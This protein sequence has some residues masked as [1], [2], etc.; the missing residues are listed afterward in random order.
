[1]NPHSY[2]LSFGEITRERLFTVEAITLFFQ[3]ILNEQV[4]KG[5]D[6]V[7]TSRPTVNRFKSGQR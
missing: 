6:W 1:L 3:G 7:I 4:A 5:R 2:P